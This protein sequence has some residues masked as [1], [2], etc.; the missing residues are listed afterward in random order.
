MAKAIFKHVKVSGITTSVPEGSINIDDE[1]EFFGNDRTL[2][3]RNKKILGLGTRHVVDDRTSFSDLC[4]DAGEQL[5]KVLGIDRSSIEALLVSSTS[6]DFRYPA[7][8]CV[9]QHRLGLP[10]SVM[11]NDFC[12]LGCS[13]YVHA[14][15]QASALIESGAV[16]RT[17][18]FAGDLKSF[19]SDR[20]NRNSNM[21]FGDAATAT[22]LEYSEK[23]TPS[24]FVTG[25]R[26][27]GW[28]KLIAP[29]GG[30]YL[31]VYSDIAGLEATDASGNVWRM[32]DDI[33]KGLDIFKFSTEA[34]PKCVGEVLELAGLKFEDV[35]YFAF[36]QANKQIVRSVGMYLGLP[37]DK[38]STLAF[39]EFGNTGVA[40]VVTDVA[41]NLSGREVGKVCMTGFGVGL[42]WA[43]GLFDFSE[44]YIGPVQTYRLPEGAMTRAEKIAY[45]I[46]YFKGETD[47][48]G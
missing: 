1:L 29:A 38:F 19:H 36:H 35:D 42:S 46:S 12:G 37:K 30:H 3:E 31:P 15:M 11:C 41:R 13:A 21:L 48:K 17:L 32:W 4:L 25:T 22:L 8:A 16:K 20:C 43:S 45:W 9:L 33:M 39:T 24:Y 14:I 44:T 34:G 47:A 5:L 2:L 28:D 40:A 18:V 10:E 27:S 6:H 23:E 26:G 7:T